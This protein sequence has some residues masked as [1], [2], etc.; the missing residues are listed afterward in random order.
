M[1]SYLQFLTVLILFVF[2]L[3]V[4]YATTRWIASY[5]K[6][7]TAGGNLE[8]METLRITGNKYLQLVRAGEKYLVIAV[9]KDEI[10]MLAEL[11]EEEL[12]LQSRTDRQGVDFKSV[13]EKLK[14]KQS[15]KEDD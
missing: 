5:Q 10:H 13:L 11:S 7:R 1:D 8:V 14:K 12:M 2:V 9:G 4:T 6:D 3:A 15:S